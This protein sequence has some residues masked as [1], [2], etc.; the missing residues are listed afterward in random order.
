MA[1]DPSDRRRA[2]AI[3]SGALVLAAVVTLVAVLV[4]TGDG[5]DAT[6]APATSDTAATVPDTAAPS[7]EPATT[8][9]S[10]GPATTETVAPT[11]S[12]AA[13]TTAA[14]P[15]TGP[16]GEAELPDAGVLWSTEFDTPGTAVDNGMVLPSYGPHLTPRAGVVSNGALW[17]D[18]D[19]T[20]W[21]DVLVRAPVGPLEGDRYIEAVVTVASNGEDAHPALMFFDDPGVSDQGCAGGSLSDWADVDPWNNMQEGRISFVVDGCYDDTTHVF[22]GVMGEYRTYTVRAEIRGDTISMLLDGEEILSTTIPAGLSLPYAGL[23][24]GQYGE[25]GGYD[26]YRFERFEVGLL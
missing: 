3:A 24:L 11:S 4:L 23:R 18:P 22:T 20:E 17:R 19:M 2:L 9:A 15:T 10:S 7:T 21:E 12:A 26:Q 1:A 8:T 5:D 13:T 6:V 14:V 25:D 16:L